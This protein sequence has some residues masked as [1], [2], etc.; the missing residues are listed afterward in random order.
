[1]RVL[2]VGDIFG[3]SGRRVASSVIPA[4]RAEEEIDFVIANGENVAG[5]FGITVPIL[6]KLRRYGI[7]C[8]TS[9]NHVWD[10][11][12][13]VEDMDDIPDLLRP[14]NYPEGSPGAGA[15]L[16]QDRIGVINAAGRTLMPRVDCPFRR[17]SE[18]IEGLGTK[19][20]IVDF[21]AESAAE[22]K[23]FALWLDGRVSGVFGTHTHVQTADEQ[24]LPNG[25]AYITDVGM[26]GSFDSVI[27][28]KQEKSINYFVHG[29]P[30]RF[31]TAKEN[32]HL[33]AVILD[34]DEESGKSI[35]IKRIDV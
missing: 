24:V 5:G 29:I 23:A 12:K 20:V 34:I 18:E 4:L 27:G 30:Q 16:F 14:V 25:T 21:H 9:G 28:V 26:T 22:K 10:K 6:R 32:E 19:T 11:K 8:V 1:V 35:S 2:C 15:R 13:I 17:V 7:D 33:N 31:D 3:K